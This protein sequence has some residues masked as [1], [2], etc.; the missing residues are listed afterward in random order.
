MVKGGMGIGRR[1]G[2]TLLEVLI[3][4]SVFALIGIASFRVL[5]GVIDSQKTGDRH[6]AQLAT[7]QK[8]MSIIDR[9]LQ[10]FVDRPIRNGPDQQV[11]ALLVNTGTYPLELTRGGWR[12]PLMLARS[13]LQRVAYDIGPHPGADDVKSP[14][15]G[16]KRQYLRRI[17]WL[18]LDRDP[19][20]Q[21]IVQALLPDVDDLQVSVISDQGLLSQWPPAAATGT[22]KTP[23]P[24]ALEFSFTSS[25]FGT[26]TRIYKLAW[27]R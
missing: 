14:H 20:A 5:S 23:E 18:A 7:F 11:G 12:N 16:D 17:Y 4:I 15:Y 3:A 6:S 26:I 25:E 2:F 10:Q 13:S 27:Y 24:K 22:S 1:S 21:P 9:D 19:A 8:A